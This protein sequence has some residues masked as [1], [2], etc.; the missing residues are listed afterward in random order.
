MAKKVTRIE[1]D[2]Q[3]AKLEKVGIYCR[4]SS[5]TPAQIH[6]LSSQASYLLKYA[7]NHRGWMVADE[8][9]SYPYHTDGGL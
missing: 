4:V 7:L 6:S 8:G 5:S 9:P 3:L 2:P 1:P